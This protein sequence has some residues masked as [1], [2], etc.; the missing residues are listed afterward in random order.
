MCA[1]LSSLSN[2]DLRATVCVCKGL[3]VEVTAPGRSP[4]VRWSLYCCPV[5]WKISV[6]GETKNVSYIL[7]AAVGLESVP[8]T[9]SALYSFP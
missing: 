4:S 9:A 3:P 2:I 7:L 5:S 8:V 1:R 6:Y